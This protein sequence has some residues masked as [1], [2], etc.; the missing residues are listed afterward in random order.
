[1]TRR[2][3]VQES[4]AIL[5][6]ALHDAEELLRRVRPMLDQVRRAPGAVGESSMCD[7]YAQGDTLYREINHCVSALKQQVTNMAQLGPVTT[8]DGSRGWTATRLGHPLAGP[9]AYRLDPLRSDE[10]GELT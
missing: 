1:M 3:E 7:L 9:T 5:L 10:L 8:S 4:A 2:E 6:D